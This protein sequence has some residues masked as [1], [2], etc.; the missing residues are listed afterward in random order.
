MQFKATP[1]RAAMR[2]CLSYKMTIHLGVTKIM[3]IQVRKLKELIRCVSNRI[4]LQVP[5]A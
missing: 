5:S 1:H 2:C 3:Y 4:Q